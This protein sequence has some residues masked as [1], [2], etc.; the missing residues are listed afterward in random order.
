MELLENI[1]RLMD[2]HPIASI[3][4]CLMIALGLIIYKVVK[5]L[6]NNPNNANRTRIDLTRYPHKLIKEQ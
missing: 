6:M 4:F 5:L 1:M 3:A 2:N